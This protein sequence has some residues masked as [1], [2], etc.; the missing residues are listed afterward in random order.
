MFCLLV[1]SLPELDRTDIGGDE[2]GAAQEGVEG[3]GEDCGH[4]SLDE[5]HSRV[6]R[7]LG[8]GSLDKY[9]CSTILNTY[10]LC[11]D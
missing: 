6:W 2:D 10:C 5:Q 11:D 8:Q 7:G 4:Y 1:V 3:S 9:V